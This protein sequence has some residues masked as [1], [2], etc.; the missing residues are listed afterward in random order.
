MVRTRHPGI[1]KRGS[2]YVVTYRVGGKQRKE[3]V[4]TLDQALRLKRAREADRD[5]GE[6]H[7]E[8]RRP[9]G[10]YAMEW[11]DTYQ[12]TGRRGFSEGSRDEYRRSLLKYA[13]PFFDKRLNRTLSALTPRDVARWIAWL[14]DEREQGRSL[15]DA[16]VRRV[17]AP[18]R[19]CLA[20]A[21]REGLIRHNPADGAALPHRR[22]IDESDEPR[23]RA[24]TRDQLGMLLRVAHPRYKLMFRFAAATGLRWS[25][26]AGLR[27]SDL[28]LDGPRRRVRVR[29]AMV[30]G[31]M[32]PPK[33]EHGRRD[34]PITAELARE[35]SSVRGAAADD[36]PV[37]AS[38]RGNSRPTGT[39]CG[40]T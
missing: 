30:K 40:V 31:R 17:L 26:I 24:L 10:E 22:T 21:K 37:F 14:C 12:G 27:W 18:V 15:A 20:T 16:S 36:T 4:R 29:R 39:S 3:S 38:T 23:A 5:R 34:V 33:S 32:K 2:R 7:D 25:E 6:L 35:L 9:F 1:F 8:S 11:I 28:E 19:A 13:L